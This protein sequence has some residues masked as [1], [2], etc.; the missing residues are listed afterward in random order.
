MDTPE[1]DVLGFASWHREMVIVW[2]VINR[3]RLGLM[4][5]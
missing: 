3:A 1:I 2:H 5:R 4:N